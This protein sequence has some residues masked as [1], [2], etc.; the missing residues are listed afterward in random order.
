MVLIEGKLFCLREWKYGDE[1]ALVKYADN[2]K[3]ARF[4]ADRF[5]NPYTLKDAEF[6]INLQ[7][8]KIK[9]DTLAIDIYGEAVGGI[10]VDFK[11]DI[12]RKTALIGYWLGEPFWGK[13]IMPDAVKLMTKYVFDNFDIIHLQ[14]GVFEGNPA[15]MRV[16]EKAGFIKEGISKNALVKHGMVYDEHVYGLVR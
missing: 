16:L 8:S 3:V 4:L 5:P 11:Q 12:H 6:W 13:G 1:A 14:A 2:P 15:S 7:T 9:V 10:G